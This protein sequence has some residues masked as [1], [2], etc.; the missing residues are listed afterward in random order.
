M[1]LSA[2]AARAY[3]RGLT[4]LDDAVG[5][6]AYWRAA[7]WKRLAAIA[8]GPGANILLA[9]VLFAILFASGGGRATTDRR[10]GG[11]GLAGRRRGAA[12]RR[13]DRGD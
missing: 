10:R 1:Q 13:P 7:T 2:P 8:A 12:R 11:L 6:D 3:D 4:E 9:L 5:P